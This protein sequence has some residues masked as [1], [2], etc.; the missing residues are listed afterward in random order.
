MSQ[1][2]SAEL[3]YQSVLRFLIKFK[4]IKYLLDYIV[5][6]AVKLLLK[7]SLS[8]ELEFL[9]PLKNTTSSNNMNKFVLYTV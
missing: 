7:R 2:I 6:T 1:L 3:E 9:D 8:V 5:F 4:R